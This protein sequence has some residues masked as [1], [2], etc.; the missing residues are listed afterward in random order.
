MGGGGSR[1]EWG[2]GGGGELKPLE[3]MKRAEYPTRL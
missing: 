2:G 1:L 3:T